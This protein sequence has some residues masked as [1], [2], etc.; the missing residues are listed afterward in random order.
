M[1]AKDLTQQQK[2]WLI[3]NFPCTKNAEIAA[4]LDTSLKSL[5][6]MARELGLV[7]T[8]EFIAQTQR[9]AME[10]AARANR[11]RGGNSGK[12]NLLKGAKHRFKKGECRQKETMTPE[13][14][15]DL[16]RRIGMTRRETIAK[17]RTRIKWGLPQQTRLRLT[18][19]PIPKKNLRYNLRKHGYE[20]ARASNEAFI[21]EETR[22]SAIMEQRAERMGIRFYEYI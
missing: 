4:K 16:H 13:E 5:N 18:R 17:E 9:Y 10:R 21:T 2:A 20:I 22:R 19:C 6:R 7:K 1:K 15:A 12:A 8:R 14:F 3:E 11:A